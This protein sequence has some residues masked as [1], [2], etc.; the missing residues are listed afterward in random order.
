[1]SASFLETLNT[2]S[3]FSFSVRA[4]DRHEVWSRNRE[5]WSPAYP[6]WTMPSSVSGRGH[7]YN[8]GHYY[9]SGSFKRSGSGESKCIL[10]RIKKLVCFKWFC[11]YDL[12]RHSRNGGVPPSARNTRFTSNS[13]PL[14]VLYPSPIVHILNR[15]D[16]P[17]F[18]VSVIDLLV[19]ISSNFEL[20]IPTFLCKEFQ[21]IL[22]LI[23]SITYRQLFVLQKSIAVRFLRLRCLC[24]MLLTA[25]L[26]WI[27][28]LL[29]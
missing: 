21:S 10:R 5:I 2:S 15:M 14:C 17:G 28:Y 7:S 19:E 16:P 11:H 23:I 9:S 6:N 12:I 25:P 29:V 26:S 22:F 1:M 20:H 18:T 27:F 4:Q 13:R 24:S 3:A 8:H